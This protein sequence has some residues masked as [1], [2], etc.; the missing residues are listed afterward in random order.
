MTERPAVEIVGHG[1]A[2]AYFPGNSRPSIERALE[3][4]VDRIECDVQRTSDGSLVLGHDEN[5]L[6]DGAKVA[7]RGLGLD[8]LRMRIE[9]LLTLDEFLEL[10][11]DRSAFLLDM[12]APG[13]ERE[14]AGTIRHHAIADR[15]IVSST[16][17]LSLRRLRALVPDLSTGLSSGH[18]ASGVPIELVRDWL[19]VALGWLTPRPLI[20][21]ARRVGAGRLMVHHRVCS[22]R[23]VAIAHRAGLLVYPWTVDDEH[24]MDHL[25]GL[26]VDGI[27]SNRPDVLKERLE[28]V[29]REAMAVDWPRH[30]PGASPARAGRCPVRARGRTSLRR[31]PPRRHRVTT[32]CEPGSPAG[33]G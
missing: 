3:I 30:G 10:V 4:G 6:I 9:D 7:L 29:S 19:G 22:V 32:G 14:L 2:G 24:R 18:L 13:Y 15:T 25:I 16:Y 12:K 11:G 28:Q 5:I 26:G 17:A 33:D 21:A 8:T 20:L 1:G 31:R 23:M 27:I